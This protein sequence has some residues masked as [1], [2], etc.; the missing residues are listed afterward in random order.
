ML[1]NSTDIVS[2]I[3]NIG[4]QGAMVVAFVWFGKRFLQLNDQL[5]EKVDRVLS[6]MESSRHAMDAA[7]REFELAE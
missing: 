3:S 7:R 6:E 1:E 2:I 4:P 5:L